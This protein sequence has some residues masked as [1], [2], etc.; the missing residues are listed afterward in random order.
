MRTEEAENGVNQADVRGRG[1]NG[2]E[3]V[4]LSRLWAEDEGEGHC[5]IDA[6]MP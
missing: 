5:A 1:S 6:L 4:F 2:S 3:R